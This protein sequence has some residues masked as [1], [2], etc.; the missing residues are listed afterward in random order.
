MSLREMVLSFMGTPF[1]PRTVNSM[2][3]REMP[4]L[5]GEGWGG[6]TSMA[7]LR[8]RSIEGSLLSLRIWWALTGEDWAF[9]ALERGMRGWLFTLRVLPWVWN[10]RCWED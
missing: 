2:G 8:G 10:S 5:W 3:M 9:W 4:S 7:K 1:R 6:M